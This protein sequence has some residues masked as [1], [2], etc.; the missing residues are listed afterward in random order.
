MKSAYETVMDAAAFIREKTLETPRIGLLTGTGLG[1]LSD[2]ADAHV[3]IPTQTI[4]RFPVSTVESHEGRLVFGVMNGVELLVMH[5][6][7]HLYEGYSPEQV[8]FPIRLMRALGVDTLILT[9]AAGGLNL[10]F[11]TGD[12][13]VIRDHI[14]LAGANPLAGPNEN[15]WGE[16]FPNMV[17]AYDIKLRQLTADYGEK[18]GFG[19]RE[20]VYVGLRGPS[21]ETPAEN[22]FLRTIGAD[23]VGFSTVLEVI[24]AVH[25]GMKVLAL[26]TI[27]NINDPDH[28]EPATL[29][30]II[31]SASAA[32]PKVEALIRS[33]IHRL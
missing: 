26:S 8:V 18:L 20:G 19:I 6:R 7:V 30:E 25:T 32:A 21:L 23:A 10:S 27:T 1:H 11:Q 28:P 22:R 12:I 31:A 17:N 15:R 5:G 24:A 29:T 13:M 14:N 33:M 3:A 2:A 16:R 4:P 9:N